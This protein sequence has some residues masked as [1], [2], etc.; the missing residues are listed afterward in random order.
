MKATIF[1]QNLSLATSL[2]ARRHNATKAP[3]AGKIPMVVVQHHTDGRPIFRK[4]SKE[5]ELHP[6]D[7]L[8]LKSA[9]V[10]QLADS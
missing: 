1:D 2:R 6:E 4:G 10:P 7:A 3:A 5:W 9:G 8:T